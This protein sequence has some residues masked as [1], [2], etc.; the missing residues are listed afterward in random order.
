MVQTGAG[1][2]GHVQDG[3]AVRVQVQ[4]AAGHQGERK[5][6]AV[7]VNPVGPDTSRFPPLPTRISG[8]P[9]IWLRIMQDY[10]FPVKR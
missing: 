3:A 4:G 8:F 1:Q 9:V 7:P 6:A 10:F 5:A 2:A